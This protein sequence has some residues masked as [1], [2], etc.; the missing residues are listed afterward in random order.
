MFWIKNLKVV[1]FRC[2]DSYNVSFDNNINILV[3]KNAVGKTS[4]VESIYLMGC[5]KSHRANN[6]SLL[7]KKNQKFYSVE[8]TISEDEQID[9]LLRLYSDKKGKKISLNKKQYRN[10][11]DYIGYFKVVMFCPEDL[12]LV[13]G[14]P[15]DKRK[16]MDLNLGQIDKKYLQ[17]LIKYKNIL[18]TRN[19]YLKQI[20]EDKYDKVLLETYTNALIH[21]AKII[22]DKRKWFIEQ[23]NKYFSTK[24][25]TISCGKEVSKIV[26][27]CNVDV[28]NLL[29]TFEKKLKFDLF[30][31]TTTSGPHRDSFEVYINDEDASE[32]A[33]QGQQRTLALSLKLALAEM[34]KM[35]TNRV[36]IILDDV[37]GELD[38]DR[39]NQL[40][41]LINFN[42]QIFITTTSINNLTT[43]VIN[44]SKVINIEI[45]KDG[46]IHE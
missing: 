37:F 17:S 34:M 13:N 1:N 7:I 33:S 46:D 3:G 26:Y 9:N 8:C 36:V 29:I 42:S 43:E 20:E 18:K 10:L 16:F 6:D 19:E 35:L 2:F 14:D 30:S 15:S 39:Q 45:E 27:N 40:L 41:K 31:K 12:N 11:S 23:I 32:V 22:I 28:D 24:V 21:E 25:E 44:N 5:C 4:L 38:I